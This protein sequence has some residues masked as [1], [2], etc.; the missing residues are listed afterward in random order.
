MARLPD[1]VLEQIKIE[2][3]KEIENRKKQFFEMVALAITKAA[4]KGVA[5]G[6]GEK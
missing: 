5:S 2:P 1:P 6:D 4:N 3:D